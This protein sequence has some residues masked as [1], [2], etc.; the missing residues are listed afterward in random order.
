[1]CRVTVLPFTAILAVLGIILGLASLFAFI[2]EM[3]DVSDS[4]SLWNA[5]SFVLLTVGIDLV[6]L[7]GLTKVLEGREPNRA[8]YFFQV[9]GLNPLVI[10]LFS[11]L[12]VIVLGM[13]KVATGVGLYKWV[14][15]NLFQVVAPG[16]FGS[17]LCAVAYMLV[18]WLLGYVM[19]RRGAVVKL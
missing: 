15:V 18:C 2:D 11:E 6:V 13:I 8:T 7:A 10:Y 14:G 19:A 9:F 5:G 1:M 16:A 17:L 12:F 3:G 4:Y